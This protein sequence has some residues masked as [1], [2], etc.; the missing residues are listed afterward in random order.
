MKTVEPLLQ[1]LTINV[2]DSTYLRKASQTLITPTVLKPPLSGSGYSP[3]P[4]MRKC[5]LIPH[6]GGVLAV[7]VKSHWSFGL[8]HRRVAPSLTWL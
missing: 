4:G 8:P 6:W 1:N 7:V 3:A 5:R 2:S